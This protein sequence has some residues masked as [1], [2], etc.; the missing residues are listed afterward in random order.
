ML[1]QQKVYNL[2]VRIPLKERVLGI[3]MGIQPRV[4]KF[5]PI[6]IKFSALVKL[7]IISIL[8]KKI[9]LKTF[10]FIELDS[11]YF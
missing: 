4:Q 9:S 2:C 10:F 3:S 5:F 7:L 1:D 8:I 6:L 11:K